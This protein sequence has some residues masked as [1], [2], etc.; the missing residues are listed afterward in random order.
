ML[1]NTINKQDLYESEYFN[2]FSNISC[3]LETKWI[4]G[5]KF[6]NYLKS[7]DFIG[8]SGHIQFSKETGLRSGLKLAIVDKIKNSIDLVKIY[9][10]LCYTR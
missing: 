8:L 10:L 6:M 5:K 3:D 1:F 2:L 4:F 9:L 7:N